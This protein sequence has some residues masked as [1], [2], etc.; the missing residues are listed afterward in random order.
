[1]HPGG[2]TIKIPGLLE[3]DR[4]LVTGATGWLG[5]EILARLTRRSPQIPVLAVARRARAFS[6]GRDQRTCIE[7]D[8]A[9]VRDWRP[10]LVVHLA[11]LTRERE[12]EVG[13]QSYEVRNRKLTHRA[14]DLYTIDSVRGVVVASSGAAVALR[15]TT[16]GRLKAYDEGMFLAA[17]RDTKI[18]TVIARIWSVSGALCTKPQGFALYDLINQTLNGPV[19]QVRAP[20]EVW[21]RYVDAGEY[22]EVCLA[23]AASGASEIIDSSGEL[24]ELKDLAHCIQS[25]L[26][27]HR[28]IER[29]P[30][31]GTADEYYSESSLMQLR[32]REFSLTIS[33]LEQ[34]IS[35]SSRSLSPDMT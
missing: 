21:R 31:L 24:I 7:W 20:N 19:V 3:S 14:L 17:G 35:V 32:A 4:I 26:G 25:V 10:T 5:R 28:R 30:L 1:M 2:T 33:S 16:Y 34:Q 29:P 13:T 11:Y 27:V 9:A 8:S 12:A 15:H 22:L 18:P 23:D 6:I